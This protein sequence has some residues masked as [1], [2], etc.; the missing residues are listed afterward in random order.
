MTTLHADLI[1]TGPRLAL[2]HGFTQTRRCWGQVADDLARDHELVV[3]D[4]PGHGRSAGVVLDLAEGGAAMA[5]TAGGA[6]YLGYSMGGRFVLHTALERPHAVSGL[7]LVGATAGLESAHER[8]ARV[9]DDEA[10]ARHIEEVGIDAFLDEWLALPLFA[11]L[12]PAA[13]C[14]E[15]RR[16]NTTAG[17]ASSLRLAGTGAQVPTWDRLPELEMPVLVVAGALDTKFCALG[18][19]MAASVG[20]NATFATIEG[21]GHT[22]QLEQPDRFLAVLRPWLAE[23]GL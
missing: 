6:T 1:G 14:R 11:G 13:A 8:T 15:E 10:R 21:A 9:D 17:L 3:V 4:A 7:V 12:S 20:A 23:R 5:D 16:E 19:R 22:A 18:E 2:V